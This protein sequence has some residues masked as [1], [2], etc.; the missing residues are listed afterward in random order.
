MK[1]FAAFLLLT[2]AIVLQIE[3]TPFRQAVK[4]SDVLDEV[5]LIDG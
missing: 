4:G 2:I 1:I 3:A 5:P